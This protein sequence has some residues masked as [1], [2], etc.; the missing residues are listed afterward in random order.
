VTTGL[1]TVTIDRRYRGPLRS[2]N[3][4]YACGLLG[5]RIG[6]AAEVT[7]RLPPPLERP[8]TI[9]RDG[10][11]LLLEDGDQL[12]AEA[13]AGEPGL[14]PPAPPAPEVAAAAAAGVGAFGPPEFAECFVCGTRD[15]DS[16]LSIH[17]G[18]VPGRAGLRAGLVA[19]MWTAHDVSPEVIW[20]ATDCPGAYAAGDPGRGE[21]VLG[22]M[23][24][25]VDRLPEPGEPCVVVGWP[26]GEDGRKLF[27]G[28]A[29]YGRDG[30]P[31]AVA[32]QVWILPR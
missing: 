32:R 22:R 15:D 24:A 6:L 23:T 26:L 13:V 21:V 14:E 19:T 3:G 11:R 17:P 9:R 27:A 1:E 4:G 12:V 2:A 7:L 5:S 8:L 28:T 10:E 25:R 29:L 31:I 20:A 30:A 16:G 18:P